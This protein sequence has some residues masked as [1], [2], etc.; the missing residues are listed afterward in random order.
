MSL[1]RD[2]C[3]KAMSRIST[4]A[5]EAMMLRPSQQKHQR[6]ILA[7]LLY[8]ELLTVKELFKSVRAD[9]KRLKRVKRGGNENKNSLSFLNE[10][11][12]TVAAELRSGLSKVSSKQLMEKRSEMPT[13]WM[14][15]L[16]QESGTRRTS[17]S[18]QERLV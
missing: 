17:N 12:V 4:H 11:R 3:L 13:A 9:T 18:S 1:E 16:R 14:R 6:P 8:V 15:G 10:F 7:G 2:K 5:L